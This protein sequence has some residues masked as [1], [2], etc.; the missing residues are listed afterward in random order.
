MIFGV[1]FFFF[2]LY[3]ECIGVSVIRKKRGSRVSIKETCGGIFNQL[4][5]SDN[6]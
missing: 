4:D 6:Q 2:Y 5:R 1:G 3:R